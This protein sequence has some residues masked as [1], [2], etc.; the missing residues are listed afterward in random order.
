MLTAAT[1]V[2]SASDVRATPLLLISEQEAADSQAAPPT[3]EARSVPVPGAPKIQLLA[4][5]I[6]AAVPSPTR[7]QVKFEPGPAATIN[8]ESFK[9]R[10]GALKLDITSRITASAKVTAEGIDVSQAALPKGSHRLFIEI[11]DSQGRTA[12][13]RVEFTVQ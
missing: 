7:I 12:E 4:P 9:V 13:R 8:P 3:L 11:Q 5:D 2:M 6:N 1:L 10:Y